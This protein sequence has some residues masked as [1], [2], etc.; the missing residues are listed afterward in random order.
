[1]CGRLLVVGGCPG[2]GLSKLNPAWVD[3]GAAV[4]TGNGPRTGLSVEE[5]WCKVPGSQLFA[6]A[7]GARIG[8]RW[9]G[10]W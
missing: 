9:G 6:A 1:M 2:E 5:K 3:L 10:A 4:A 8:A 7:G